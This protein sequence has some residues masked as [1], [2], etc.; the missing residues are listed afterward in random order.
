MKKLY[1][2]YRG[3]LLSNNCEC[4]REAAEERERMIE[5]QE[6]YQH[7]SGFYAFQELIEMYRNER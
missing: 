6:E 7:N 4:E 2:P 1:C 5:E 3:E